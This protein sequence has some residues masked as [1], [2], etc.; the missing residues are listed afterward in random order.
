MPDLPIRPAV[1]ASP[2]YPFSA[3]TA[4]I[5]LDQNESFE[6][7]PAELKD[8][9]LER[10]RELPWHRYTDLNADALCNAVARHDGWAPEGTVVTTGTWVGIVPAQRGDLV[11]AAFEGIGEARVQL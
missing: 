5:K 8:L 7:F 2:D 6:D 4:P 10:L 9:A 3:V 11:L 1:L